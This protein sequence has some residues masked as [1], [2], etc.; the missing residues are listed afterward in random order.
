MLW[1]FIIIY[2]NFFSIF[3]EANGGYF[4]VFIWKTNFFIINSVKFKAKF[5]DENVLWYIFS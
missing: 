4:V 2:F 3:S 1:F 5:I